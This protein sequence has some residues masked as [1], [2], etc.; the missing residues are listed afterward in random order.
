MSLFG[1][2]IKETGSLQ[3]ESYGYD[4]AS[5]TDYENWID[6][7]RTQTLAAFVEL[8]EFLQSLPWKP[9]GKSKEVFAE[10]RD[11]AVEELVDVLHFIANNLYALDVSDEELNEVYTRKM[12]VNRERMATGGH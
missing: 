6:Y 7:V 11:S 8:G 1:T 10:D 12:N 2:W 3:K 9:W 4:P 5:E